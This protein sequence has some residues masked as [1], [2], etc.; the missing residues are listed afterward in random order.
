MSVK[1]CGIN[2]SMRSFL[3][4]RVSV[5]SQP[6]TVVDFHFPSGS[7]WPKADVGSSWIMEFFQW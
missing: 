2:W 3:S 4:R 1:F 6:E 5:G 7:L